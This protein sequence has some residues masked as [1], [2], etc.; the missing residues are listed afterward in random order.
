MRINLCYHIQ[1]NEELY[2]KEKEDE[3]IGSY[4]IKIGL[5]LII[6]ILIEH[7]MSLPLAIALGHILA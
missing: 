4:V 3:K 7:S 5:M 2:L 1:R 6:C